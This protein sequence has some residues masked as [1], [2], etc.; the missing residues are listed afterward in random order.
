MKVVM[1]I[2]LISVTL[3]ALMSLTYV[4]ADIV[5][6]VLAKRREEAAAAA[7]EQASEGELSEEETAAE[8]PAA[9][10]ISA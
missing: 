9:E 7:A 6:E 4:V 5:Q 10:E 1:I 8:M 2:F 3:F